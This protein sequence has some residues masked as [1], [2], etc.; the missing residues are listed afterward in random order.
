MR[1]VQ[2][3]VLI[4]TVLLLVG[5]SAAA[6]ERTHVFTSTFTIP[7]ALEIDTES[8]EPL[9]ELLATPG[10]PATAHL[11]LRVGT[12]DWPLD[13]HLGLLESEETLPE[14]SLFYQFVEGNELAGAWVSLPQFSGDNPVA[15]L[16][17]P[18]WTN[19]TLAVRVAPPE[20]TESETYAGTLRVL[21]RSRSGKV[22]SVD[23]PV[24]LAVD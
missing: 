10:A 4:A 11:P 19:Y 7:A 21:L 20:D 9:L 8:A 17:S 12:N 1:K 13:L 16:A 22:K 5:L 23:I 24:E 2:C 6:D 14:F 3:T 18:A 15:V